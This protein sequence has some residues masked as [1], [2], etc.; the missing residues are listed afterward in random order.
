MFKMLKYK[1]FFL[2]LNQ[3]I[4]SAT[5]HRFVEEALQAISLGTSTTTKVVL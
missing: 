1:I 2:S 3:E 4:W 5:E